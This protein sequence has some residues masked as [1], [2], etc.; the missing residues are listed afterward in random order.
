MLQYLAAYGAALLAY[1]G[2]DFTFLTIVA[3]TLYQRELGPLLAPQPQIAPAVAFYLLYVAGVVLFVVSP[4]LARGRWSRAV[5]HGAVFGLV[6]YATYDLTNLATLMGFSPVITAV[7]M[8]WGAVA[9]AIVAL[10]GYAAGRGVARG[11]P[12]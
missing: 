1:V 8:T 7:D 12:A 9:T 5:I 11:K 6:A 10:A 3:R 4:A 2:L